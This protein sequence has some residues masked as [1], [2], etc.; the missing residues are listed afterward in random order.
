MAAVEKQ[1]AK[2]VDELKH[3]KSD[4]KSKL[5]KENAKNLEQLQKSIA[6]VH[7]DRKKKAELEKAKAENL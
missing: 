4:L 6:S 3:E 2:E 5:E 7:E 1:Q